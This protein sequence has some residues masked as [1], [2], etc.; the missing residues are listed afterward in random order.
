MKNFELFKPVYVLNSRTTFLFCILLAITLLLIL[1]RSKE[2]LQL[3]VAIDLIP[4]FYHHISNLAISY[5]L[6]TGIGLM[7]LLL[8]YNFK[9]IILLG[10]ILIVSNFVY[11]T[12]LEILNTK[13][14]VDAYFGL[15]GTMI[16]FLFLYYIKN[17]G[18]TL[19][20]KNIS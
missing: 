7:W 6:Y 4:D 12:L 14:I 3:D 18:L 20:P 1:G 17:F 10:V 15:T 9:L 8:G 19:N 2:I 13:D 5:M 11:E 16:G